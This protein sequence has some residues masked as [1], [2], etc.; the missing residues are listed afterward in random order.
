MKLST[1]HLMPSKD[2]VFPAFMGLG[3]LPNTERGGL[4]K[5]VYFSEAVVMHGISTGERQ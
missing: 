3:F 5:T 4:S 1:Q 2:R